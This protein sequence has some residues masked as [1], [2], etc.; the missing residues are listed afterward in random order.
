M[1]TKGLNNVD[2]DIRDIRINIKI[3]SYGYL[4]IEEA[5]QGK[6]EN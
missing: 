5:R 3:D 6:T 4:D 2:K 1:K